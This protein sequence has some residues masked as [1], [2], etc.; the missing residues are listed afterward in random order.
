MGTQ[1]NLPRFPA[2]GLRTQLM[3]LGSVAQPLKRA[4]VRR[5]GKQDEREKKQQS[6]TSASD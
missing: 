2:P 4:V 6:W 1:M 5:K 3:A